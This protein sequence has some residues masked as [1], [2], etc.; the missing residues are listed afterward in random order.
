LLL[1]EKKEILLA[2]QRAALKVE[3]SVGLLDGRSDGLLVDVMALT[4][5]D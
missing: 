2:A 5:V 4:S 3:M 1:V